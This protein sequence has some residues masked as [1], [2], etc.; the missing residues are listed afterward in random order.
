MGISIRF[1]TVTGEGLLYR[2]GYDFKRLFTISEYYD[3]DRTTDV[4]LKSTDKMH[5]SASTNARIWFIPPRF[6]RKPTNS[7]WLR[8]NPTIITLQRTVLGYLQWDAA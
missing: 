8:E 3:R 6:A 4:E 2:T 5:R 1:W 7:W